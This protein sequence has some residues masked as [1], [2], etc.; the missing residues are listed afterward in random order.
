MNNLFNNF[1]SSVKETIITLPRKKPVELLLIVVAFSIMEYYPNIIQLPDGLL[2]YPLL[3]FLTMSLNH[4]GGK[5]RIFYYLSAMLVILIFY[6]GILGFLGIKLLPLYILATIVLLLSNSHTGDE[7]CAASFLCFVKGAFNAVLLSSVAMW[8]I[9]II[10]TSVDYIFDFSLYNL[11]ES[12]LFNMM[13]LL[14]APMLF[15]SLCE[16]KY[17]G[18]SL[19]KIGEIVFSKLFVP[20]LFVY[21]LILYIYFAQI[22]ILWELPKGGIVYLTLLFMLSAMLLGLVKKLSATTLYEWLFSRLALIL[23]PALVMFWIAVGYRIGEYGFTENRIMIVILG[24]AVSFSMVALLVCRTGR[25]YFGA[26]LIW[27]VM[28]LTALALPVKHISVV[29]QKSRVEGIARNLGFV[30]ENGNVDFNNNHMVQDFTAEQREI[31]KEFKDIIRYLK[32]NGEFVDLSFDIPENIVKEY[33]GVNAKY[34][35]L[36]IPDGYSYIYNAKMLRNE[37]GNYQLDT[38]D[39][40]VE[41]ALE[42]IQK[43]LLERIGAAN[44]KNLV[45]DLREGVY[46][47]Q[48]SYFEHEKFFILIDY[49]NFNAFGNNVEINWVEWSKIFSKERL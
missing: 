20:A 5:K 36:K 14:V 9:T 23:L 47:A 49:I 26:L 29:S 35:G 11:L 18:V 48:L 37:N 39:G 17:V 32:E 40:V 21:V 41:V 45:E 25:Q 3:L 8:L 33:I 27:V 19:G 10:L 46:D 31:Y 12:H 22:V 1:L 34:D 44:K 13:Y 15:V 28:M 6:K 2:L 42:D 16:K 43:Q 24:A 7:D 4:L 38:K 30:D